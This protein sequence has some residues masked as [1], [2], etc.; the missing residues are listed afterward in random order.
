MYDLFSNV[1]FSPSPLKAVLYY[2]VLQET[3]GRFLTTV[4]YYIPSKEEK[5]VTK[6]LLLLQGKVNLSG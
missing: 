5:N 3:S 2:S 4:T 1:C 6:G